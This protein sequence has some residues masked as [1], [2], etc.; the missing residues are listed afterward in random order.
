MLKANLTPYKD[1]PYR[2]THGIFLRRNCGSDIPREGAGYWL[3][4]SSLPSGDF[5][6]QK[7]AL[8]G[9]T[10]NKLAVI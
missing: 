7:L 1:L 8:P 6:I 9:R 2:A 10:G 4:H 5:S 3:L